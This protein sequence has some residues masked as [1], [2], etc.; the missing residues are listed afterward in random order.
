MSGSEAPPAADIIPGI[1]PAREVHLF[2]G[3]PHAGKTCIAAAL[4]SALANGHTIFGLQSST[5]P[6]LGVICV[7]RPWDP[8]WWRLV[9]LE[10][11]ARYSIVDDHTFSTTRLKKRNERILVL[12]HCL[13]QLRAPRGAVILVDPFALFLGGDLNHYDT[14]AVHM[15]EASRLCQSRELTL[16]GVLHAGKQSSDPKQRYARAIDRLVGTTSQT[17]HA[18]TSLH[19][20]TPAE[21]G[22][23]WHELYFAPRHRAPMALRLRRRLQDGLFEPVEASEPTERQRTRHKRKLE[24][25]E[26]FPPDGSPIYITQLVDKAETLLS[27]KR[28]IVYR[29]LAHLSVDKLVEQVPGEPGFWRR[30]VAVE[31]QN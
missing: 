9:G 4:F 21:T 14:C 19:L 8:W 5:P 6:F 30:T 16:I 7:D 15:I 13:A 25:L 20:A 24:L 29:Y 23:T 10:D 28:S 3:A 31:P 12:E 26:L 2:S 1:L 11:V 22:E 27:L 17:G 18:G